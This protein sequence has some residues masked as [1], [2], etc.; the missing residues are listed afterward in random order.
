[1]TVK[2][3][4][5]GCENSGHIMINTA[6]KKK[7]Q[8]VYGEVIIPTLLIMKYLKSNQLTLS[9]AIKP[10][11]EAYVISGEMN[12]PAKDF[13]LLV[14]K[15][16]ANLKTAKFSEVDGLSAQDP[17]GSW[18]INVRPSQTEPLVRVNIEAVS[19]QKLEELKNRII[20]LIK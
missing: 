2:K 18:F 11:T 6:L 19:Q 5:F 15:I 16:K 14:K 8:F 1:M 9:Q 20:K 4:L 13:G 3:L 12:F 17:K 10:F 7:Q